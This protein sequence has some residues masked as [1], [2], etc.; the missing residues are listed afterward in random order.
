MKEKEV[1]KPVF[2]KS[3]VEHKL[4]IY[5]MLPKNHDSIVRRTGC[6]IVINIKPTNIKKSQQ[7]KPSEILNTHI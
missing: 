6:T 4:Y 3:F 5:K 7:V 1:A 2:N